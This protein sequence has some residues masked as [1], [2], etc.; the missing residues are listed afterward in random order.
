MCFNAKTPWLFF[1]SGPL[2]VRP[3]ASRGSIRAAHLGPSPRG[4]RDGTPIPVPALQ[5]ST[6]RRHREPAARAPPAPA[7]HPN[8]AARSRSEAAGS[9]AGAKRLDCRARSLPLAGEEAR[10]AASPP[11]HQRGHSAASPEG[12][13]PSPSC[14][15]VRSSYAATRRVRSSKRPAI[16][17]SRNDPV[18]RQEADPATTASCSS[19]G[20]ESV[21]PGD[22]REPGH[23]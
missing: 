22:A 3:A 2:H 6:L 10:D 5:F 18:S 7:R 17:R 20:T 21:R 4:P 12:P 14:R 13:W 15:D 11:L 16:P 19:P 8:G 9:R 23:S 1:A